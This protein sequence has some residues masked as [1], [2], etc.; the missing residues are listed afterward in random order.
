[1]AEDDTHMAGAGT[2]YRIVFQFEPRWKETLIC[3]SV[4]GAF[5]LEMSM[6]LPMVYLPT[7]SAWQ[8]EAP[9]WSVHCWDS[10]H[11]QLADWCA[12]ENIP[13]MVDEAASVSSHIG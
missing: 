5:A 9:H 12:K 7:K 3:S 4:F 2:S 8:R 11:D 13:L 1:M 6:G 10:L